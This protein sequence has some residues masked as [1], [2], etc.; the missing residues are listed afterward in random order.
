MI[1][2]A[3]EHGNLEISFIEKTNTQSREEF[4]NLIKEFDE[5]QS[6]NEA[7]KIAEEKERA[8]RAMGTL[9]QILAERGELWVRIL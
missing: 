3:I 5:L 1:V 6:R 9:Q 8:E 4:N 7:R 2:N